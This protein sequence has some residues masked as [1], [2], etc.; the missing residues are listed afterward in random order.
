MGVR[1]LELLEA[2]SVND[3]TTTLETSVLTPMKTPSGNVELTEALS[4]AAAVPGTWV[5]QYPS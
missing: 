4:A 3:R 2:V 5:I 1:L